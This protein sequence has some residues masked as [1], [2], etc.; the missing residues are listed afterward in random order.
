MSKNS[1]KIFDVH[2]NILCWTLLRAAP[3]IRRSVRRHLIPSRFSFKKA[4]RPRVSLAR[5][6]APALLTQMTSY[7]LL[8]LGTRPGNEPFACPSTF[9]VQKK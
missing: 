3:H 9:S 5:G 1:K 2:Q 6:P 7:Y 8:V 4:N